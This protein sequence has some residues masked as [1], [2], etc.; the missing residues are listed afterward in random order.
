[1]GS[2][3]HALP[4]RQPFFRGYP[5]ARCRLSD[6]LGHW[7]CGT[8]TAERFMHASVASAILQYALILP[9]TPKSRVIEDG[10]DQCR[11]VCMYVC[12]H[13]CMF[14][15]LYVCVYVYMSRPC[16]VHGCLCSVANPKPM[17]RWP[18][19][20]SFGFLAFGSAMLELAWMAGWLHDCMAAWLQVWMAA[21]LDVWMAEWL[22]GWMV[23]WLHASL[24]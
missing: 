18:H 5:R 23:G 4:P 16:R 21:W 3:W 12:M 17:A 20:R 11:Y 15:C 22:D 9:H 2:A 14:V 7:V 24:A 19:H 8:I 1:M 6:E 10:H 13:A